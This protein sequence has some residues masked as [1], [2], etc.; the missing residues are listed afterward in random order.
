MKSELRNE[1]MTFQNQRNVQNLF[2]KH[3]LPETQ[4]FRMRWENQRKKSRCAEHPVKCSKLVCMASLSSINDISCWPRTSWP[5][6]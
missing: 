2:G 4:I 5:S 6:C 3:Y 1:Y